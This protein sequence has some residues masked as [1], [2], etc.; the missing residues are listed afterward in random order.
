MFVGISFIT[1]SLYEKC[2]KK[3]HNCT[4]DLYIVEFHKVYKPFF[5]ACGYGG[6]KGI[7]LAGQNCLPPPFQTDKN[8]PQKMILFKYN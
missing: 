6:D 3:E 1:K 2:F 8:K 4:K 7:I 5:F